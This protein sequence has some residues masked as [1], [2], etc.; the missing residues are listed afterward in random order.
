MITIN[1]N[2]QHDCP[3][4]TIGD[5]KLVIHGMDWDEADAVRS[6]YTEEG[7][8]DLYSLLGLE[9]HSQQQG[10]CD[11]TFKGLEVYCENMADTCGAP[12]EDYTILIVATTRQPL[13]LLCANTVLQQLT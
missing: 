11:I 2:E 13:G 12:L 10:Q 9:M 4:V 6:V 8:M 3:E 7:T 1:R 5:W